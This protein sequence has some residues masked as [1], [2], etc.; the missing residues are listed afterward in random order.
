MATIDVS[1]LQEDL[2]FGARI[3][4]VTRRALADEAVRRR[5]REVFEDRGVLVFAGVERSDE[6]LVEISNVIGPPQDIPLKKVSRVDEEKSLGVLEFNNEPADANIFEIDGQ[7][8][9]GWICWH[10]DSCYTKVLCRGAVLRVVENPPDGGMTGFADGI[11]L[12]RDISPDLR[13]EFEDAR[14][15]YHPWL[16]FQH[17]RFGM[18][19]RFRLISQQNELVRVLEETEHAPRSVHPAV[20]TR[21][22]GEKVL[23][24]CPYQADGILG[25][26]GIEGDARLE[27]LVQEIYAKMKPYW[28]RWADDDMVVWD[29]W[30]VIHSAGGH[31]PQHTRCVHRS[32]IDGDYGLGAF[33]SEVRAYA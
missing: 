22:T 5:I 23:H 9:S 2:S 18:P 11:Q 24:V 25:R 3:S 31:K 8:V 17:Q 16:M 15:L 19:E 33:E 29:N 30:R 10:F 14:I 32:T 7:A 4:G 1:P 12:Y 26:E 20:W 27:A 13:R 28:H 21:A 6:M